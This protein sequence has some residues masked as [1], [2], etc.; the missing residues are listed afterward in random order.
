MITCRPKGR[1]SPHMQEQDP[2]RDGLGCNRKNQKNVAIEPEK[3][4]QSIHNAWQRCHQTIHEPGWLEPN[5]RSG[6]T[7]G[8]PLHLCRRV[9]HQR[10]GAKGRRDGDGG[11]AHRN[12]LVREEEQ[13]CL[14]PHVVRA[15]VDESQEKPT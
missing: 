2:R 10:R 7:E 12:L 3:E 15:D 14:R 9:D 4:P 6:S 8:P 13:V 11:G 1:V 5:L